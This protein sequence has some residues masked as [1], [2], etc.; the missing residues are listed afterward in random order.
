[1]EAGFNLEI[2]ASEPLLRAPVAIDFDNKGRIWV[3]EMP[4]YMHNIEGHGENEPNGTIKILEDL[5]GDGKIDHAKI[6][7][8]SLVLPRAL[9][10]VYGGLLYAEPPNLWFA[11]IEDDKPKKL[12]LIDSLYATEG[13]PE[14]QPN[15]LHMNIDNWIY[16]AKSNF[17]YQRR[18]GVWKKEATTFR[19][20]WGISSDNFGR[21][22][23]N[24][25]VRQ[26]IGD[27]ILPNQ[28]IKNKYFVPKH[29]VN[30]LLTNDQRVY[31]VQPVLVNRGYAPGILN[32][33]SL[34]VNVTAACGPLVYRGGNFPEDYE[35]NVFVCL[36][37]A[38]LI[39]RNILSFEGNR[40]IARQAWE[41][42]EFLTSLDMGF[43]PVSLYNGPDG[44]LYVVDMHLGVLGHHAYL[45]PYLKKLAR[46]KQ[47]D[48]IVDMGRILKVSHNS[49]SSAIKPNFD[50]IST[51]DLLQL[52]KSKNGWIRDRA[53]QLLIHKNATNTIPALRKMAE[54]TAAPLTQMHALY[55]LKGLDALTFELLEKC[56]ESGHPQITSH[57]L[58]LLED[59]ATQA[60]LQ[61]YRQLF[62]TLFLKNDPLIDSYLASSLGKWMEVSEAYFL[63]KL[64]LMAQKYNEDPIVQ[65]ALL[66]G[67]SGNMER[68]LTYLK[69][70][71]QL[72]DKA[73]ITGLEQSIIQQQEDKPN[74]I[75]S[76]HFLTED[77]RTLGAK[78]FRQICAACHGINGMGTEGLAPPLLN[79]EYLSGSL[80]RL[81]LIVLHGLSGPI[82]VGNEPFDHD[83]SM[84]GLLSN[85]S[86]SD[87]D[88]AG[89]IVYVS[90]AFSDEPQGLKP[91]EV[92][93]LRNVK[94][95]SGMEFT[96]PELR[97]YKK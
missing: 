47:M 52:L 8:D 5:D 96:E 46:E 51:A 12:V 71:S 21:L 49:N 42:K 93:V 31:P 26:L 24:D 85:A 44:N 37:E 80:D 59:F 83:L 81:G 88:I 95:A 63:P 48:T 69:P 62:E 56:A 54:D 39:K 35:E 30:Q 1:M 84:P 6:F 90:N 70:K 57:A 55:T 58:I 4:G 75:F 79:S 15:G 28:L 78:V 60:N 72:P 65:E 34:L 9:S 11:E 27:H 43:R 91:E 64:E 25:N 45:S 76:E 94:S 97:A 7:L 74:R 68:A 10:L 14:H 41:G 50:Q 66:S 29:G 18:N 32:A 2:I 36:P 89:V 33:D 23:Y 22:Y 87:E 20:Q 92:Q 16:N 73:L 61:K 19:G 86:L 13:N 53:Q 77:N 3:A 67:L 40:T 82:S 38:N 17:R